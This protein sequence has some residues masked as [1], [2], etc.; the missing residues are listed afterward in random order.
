MANALAEEDSRSKQ[1]AECHAG[2][3][4][5]QSNGRIQMANP[6]VKLEVVEVVV[7]VVDQGN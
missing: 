2:S 5:C 1:D 7:E 3:Q 4:C 6:V